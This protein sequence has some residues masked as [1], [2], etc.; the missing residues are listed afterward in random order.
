MASQAPG[1][2]SGTDA[3]RTVAMATWL[4]IDGFSCR[5]QLEHLGPDLLRSH[6][7]IAGAPAPVRRSWLGLLVTRCRADEVLGLRQAVLRPHQRL[8][9]VRF[10]DDEGPGHRPLLRP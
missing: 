9:E 3:E 10:P 7:H 8:D 6:D 2:R 1:R 4:V 5:T